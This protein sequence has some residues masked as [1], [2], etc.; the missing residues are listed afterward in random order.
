MKSKKILS[1]ALICLAFICLSILP[2]AAN[3]DSKIA[4]GAKMENFSLPDADGKQQSFD[5]LKGKNGTV[6][7]FL[8]VQC[9]VVNKFYAAR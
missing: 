1:S 2:F 8:S 7:V 4:I 6:V 5:A 3:A 9:P